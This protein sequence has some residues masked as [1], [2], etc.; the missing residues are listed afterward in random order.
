MS[1][2]LDYESRGPELFAVAITFV[3]LAAIT[4]IL[5][6]YVRVFLVKAFGWDDA[7]MIIALVSSIAM[8]HSLFTNML[9]S[10]FSHPLRRLC[11][12]RHRMGD[13]Q[14]YEYAQ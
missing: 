13:R 1:T 4:V 3:S 8:V 11:D 10:A 5:R 6:T 14:A 7:W 2:E 12:R 9:S